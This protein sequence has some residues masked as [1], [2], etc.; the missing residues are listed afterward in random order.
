MYMQQTSLNSASIRIVV[1]YPNVGKP[2]LYNKRYIR[3][4]SPWIKIL[5][6]LSLGLLVLGVIYIVKLYKINIWRSLC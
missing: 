4:S 3:P 2:I 5:V 1:D 6:Y